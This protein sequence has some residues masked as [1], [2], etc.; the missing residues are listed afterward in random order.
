[1]SDQSS[2]HP[3]TPTRDAGVS[4]IELLVVLAILAATFALSTSS[5][6]VTGSAARLQPMAQ[7][8]AA[9]LRLARTLSIAQSHPIK[10]VV[11]AQ[12]CS[13]HIETR[14]ATSIRPCELA[15]APEIASQNL[16]APGIAE[17]IFFPDGSSTGGQFTLSDKRSVYSL[18]VDWLTGSVTVTGSSR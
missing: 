15:L 4:L 10:I 6:R 3:E 18:R 8:M 14:G 5:L 9:D 11:D 12:A 2:A 7:R 1:M 13:Y 17:L 16:T